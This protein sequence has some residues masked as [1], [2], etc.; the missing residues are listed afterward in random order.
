M[1]ALEAAPL[2]VPPLEAVLNEGL[3]AEDA[4]YQALAQRLGC[5]Y[6]SGEP[7][8]APACD[9][10]KSIRCGVAP[11]AAD[12]EAPRA[13]IAPRGAWVS[14][15]IEM[16]AGGRLD[17]AAFAVAAPQRLRALI[18]MSRAP[19]VL[20]EA[21]G[22]LP[23]VMSAR[24]RMSAAQAAM[25]GLIAA[26][27]VALGATNGAVLSGVLI[28]GLWLLFLAGILLRSVAAVAEGVAVR[29]PPLSDDELPA[30]TVIAA[31]HREAEVVP[32]LVKALDALDYPR[33][34]L[35]IK[36]VVERSD[37]ETLATLLAL[38]LP[39]RYEI[40]VAPPG[41]PKTKPRALNIALAEARGELIVVYDAE[42]EPAP[43]QLRLAAARFAAESDLDCLQARLAIRNA[44]DSRLSQLFA[45]EYAALFDLINPGLC[46]LGLPIA[47]GGSSNHFRRDSL[48]AA[49][50]WDEWNVAEDADLGVRLARFRYRVASLDSDT[51]EEAPHELANW[52]RQ[53]TRWQKGWLQT[54]L[55]HSREPRRFVRDL[56]PARAAAAATLVFGSSASALLW[57]AY[58]V[59]VVRRALAAGNGVPSLM[60]EAADVLV[61]VLALAGVWAIV[62]PALVAA[63]QRAVRLP[64]TTLALLPAYYLLVTAAAW[65]A[66]VELI[67][68]PHH[69]AKTAHGRTP[70]AANPAGRRR[71]AAAGG[72]RIAGGEFEWLRGPRRR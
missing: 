23:E 72:G 71:S 68:R 64:L 19:A 43:D 39:A 20:A 17:P 37:P 48:V 58:A 27:A 54:F 11:L 63:R 12:G 22:R 41:A 6:Y 2:D 36:I 28:A 62:V 53:R 34:K 4:Y 57:P 8:F 66:I 61:Y 9:P 44:D 50:G 46:A 70:A 38:K 16:T 15:L 40:V 7:P 55:T 35:D 32:R 69:W 26:A 33:G 5:A 21:L 52:F 24:R 1:S 25:A 3:I 42:D 67:V 65:T 56:G 14:G 18:R 59:D 29:P 60:R 10:S 13:V 30:Y 45:I 51:L 31:L 49:G 47:L